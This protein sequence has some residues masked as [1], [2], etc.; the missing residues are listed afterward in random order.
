MAMKCLNFVTM[1]FLLIVIAIMSSFFYTSF[2]A[3][4]GI[5]GF[6]SLGIFLYWLVGFFVPCKIDD[7]DVIV[8]PQVQVQK[9]A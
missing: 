5:I 6:V 4:Q 3:L 8:V 1:L 7:I 9:Q 2:P